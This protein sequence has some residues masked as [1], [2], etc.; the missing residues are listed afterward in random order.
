[1]G[2][3]NAWALEMEERVWDAVNQ[4]ITNYDNVLLYVEQYMIADPRYVAK[5]LN[6]A[7]GFDSLTEDALDDVS[8]GH[9]SDI[10]DGYNKYDIDESP[11]Y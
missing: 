7:M 6:E 9:N 10:I 11:D 8:Q 3:V 4:G 1:M 2:K 5:I